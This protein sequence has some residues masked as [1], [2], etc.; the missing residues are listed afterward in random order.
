MIRTLYQHNTVF[1]I[2][3]PYQWE[4]NRVKI[5]F[6]T[7]KFSQ[8]IDPYPIM[9]LVF[10]SKKEIWSINVI[11]I[12]YILITKT[13][14]LA[15]FKWAVHKNCMGGGMCEE[16]WSEWI[17]V[18][19]KERMWRNGDCKERGGGV[20]GIEKV[21]RRKSKNLS[22]SSYVQFICKVPNIQL[23]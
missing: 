21:T 15:L 23:F 11:K 16:W 5:H 19:E 20:K 17:K 12:I 3:K 18:W 9:S 2:L 22:N 7:P 1:F 4:E 14:C 8:V 6:T 13:V 10:N